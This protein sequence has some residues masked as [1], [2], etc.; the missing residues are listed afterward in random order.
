MNQK[1][2]NLKS[3]F[4]HS[5]SSRGMGQTAVLLMTFSNAVLQTSLVSVYQNTIISLFTGTNI[6]T[7]EN[8]IW[9]YF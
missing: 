4:S 2:I 1:F 6:I 3:S 9:E 5:R 8:I 7:N